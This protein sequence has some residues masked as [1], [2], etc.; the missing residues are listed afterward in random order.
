MK[1]LKIFRNL[2]YLIKPY[3]K[4]AK[5]YLLGKIA[6][7]LLFSPALALI[8][9][10]RVQA[11]I[12]AITSG[13]TMNATLMTAAVYVAADLGLT[14]LRWL[15]ILLYDRWKTV[16]MQ[17]KINRSIY[18]QAAASDYKYFD[19][20]E[21]YNSFTFAAGELAAR[22]E[23]ALQIVTT[24]AGEIAV[25]GTMAAYIATLGPW[26]ALIAVTGSVLIGFAQI[27]IN[28]LGIART[29]ES[30]PFDRKMQ[31]VHRTAYQNRYAADLKS[32]GASEM[33][34]SM[35]DGGG[36]GKVGV[37]KKYA[38]PYTR[39]NMLM[40]IAYHLC[41]FSLFAYLIVCAFTRALGV[42]ALAG[43]FAAALRLNGR[44]NQLT[45][46]SSQAMETS[47]YADKIRE[48]FEFKSDIE[49]SP[50]GGAEPPEGAF[51]VELRDVSFAYP[52]SNFGLKNLNI[53]I[54]PG[55]KIAIVG[56]NGAGKTTL[57]KLLL[58][59][60]EVDGGEILYNGKTVRDY[61]VHALRRKIGSAFQQT[62]LYALTVRENLCVYGEVSDEKLR[63][64]LR[65][66]GL[67]LDLDAEVTRE[68]DEKGLHLS[69]GEAQKLALVRLLAG[70][71][72]LLLLDEPS[73]AL[74]PLSEYN[75]TRL[76]FDGSR[77]TTIMVAHRL[78]TVR[79]ADRIYLISNGEVAEQGTH[80]ELMSLGGKYAEMFAKQAEN[81]A[82]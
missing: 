6:L 51:A 70:E 77:T 63:G 8:D 49:A 33:I 10:T 21:F 18:E 71:F 61:D 60:Y 25:V 59:L 34:M 74:D 35:F 15:F 40:F 75:M 28:K 62:Q 9:V 76:M 80:D 1:P 69:G 67:E 44:L 82:R 26:A 13:G 79:N 31:Y 54:A 41:E 39:M 22:A 19:N 17:V 24:F 58:R 81:Y 27:K 53:S 37:F 66:A 73:S 3:W 56:E 11:I 64:L 68:F 57:S 65:S 38:E 55:E 43:L 23:S 47:L 29:A 30:L 12:D 46:L 45:E 7:P 52:N 14:V 2:L 32:T 16:D 42:G 5:L 36:R 4:H 20:P 48:F 50:P 78:S 72:G